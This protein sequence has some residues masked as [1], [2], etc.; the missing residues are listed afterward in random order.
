MLHNAF[1]DWRPDE[2]HT[3][4][5]IQEVYE[6]IWQKWPSFCDGDDAYKYTLKHLVDLIENGAI[7]SKDVQK[8][9][10]NG[11][12]LDKH[13]LDNIHTCF[14]SYLHF[15]DN[16][17][18]EKYRVDM[19]EYLAIRER[20]RIT[21]LRSIQHIAKLSNQDTLKKIYQRFCH[22]DCITLDSSRKK[23][24]DRLL[25]EYYLL[26]TL[27]M[28]KN[29]RNDVISIVV[30]GCIDNHGLTVNFVCFAGYIFIYDEYRAWMMQ[31]FEEPED[32][33]ID[34]TIYD[35]GN[36]LIG[37]EQA[38]IRQNI[39]P[40]PPPDFLDNDHGQQRDIAN[41]TPNYRRNL[42]HIENEELEENLGQHI[43]GNQAPNMNR[44]P[45]LAPPPEEVDI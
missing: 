2:T 7:V 9:V 1:G 43:L 21:N 16:K 41:I 6:L 33:N 32:S 20:P 5:D 14:F 26:H 18:N 45:N 12:E 10:I 38:N 42:D 30:Q 8:H 11:C 25:E 37:H 34:P 23:N 4:H 35:I 29:A 15:H 39:A 17:M 24:Y 13:C 22:R 3:R 27:G 44:H 31:I 40:P 36:V 19:K 28:F